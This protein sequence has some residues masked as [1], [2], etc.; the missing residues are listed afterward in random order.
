MKSYRITHIG[1]FMT[2]LLT[3][4]CFDSF[5]LEQAVIRM[6]VTYTID[7]HRNA[8]FYS[9]EDREDSAEAA[10]DF[11]PWSNVRGI[12]R[13]MIKGAAAPVSFQITLRLKPEYVPGTLKACDSKDAVM[14]V[15]SLA[16]NVRLRENGLHIVTGVAIKGFSMD[17]SVDKIWDKTVERFLNSKGILFEEDV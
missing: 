17:H 8:D 5:L 12:C 11:V 4:E 16:I 2:G 10:Y 15:S 7:G 3:T 6:A 14:N 13:E 1:S 9:R